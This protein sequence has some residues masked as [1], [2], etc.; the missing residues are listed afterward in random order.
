MTGN[1]ANSNT[2]LFSHQTKNNGDGF[3]YTH[4]T[5]IMG[6]GIIGGRYSMPPIKLNSIANKNHRR[7]S[8]AVLQSTNGNDKVNTRIDVAAAAVAFL[9]AQ[10][11]IYSFPKCIAICWVQPNNH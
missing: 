3:F 5:R 1:V 2:F 9:A 10:D 7:C 8:K 6:N 11:E 4:T